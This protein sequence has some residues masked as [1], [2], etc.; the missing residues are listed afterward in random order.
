MGL[1]DSFSPEF[2]V[3]NDK[4]ATERVYLDRL[5]VIDQ[6]R[7]TSEAHRLADQVLCDIA[8]QAGYGD[9]VEQW[10]YIKKHY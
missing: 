9:V 2:P 5:K 4:M 7:D 8:K 1:F 3:E 6:M 10:L